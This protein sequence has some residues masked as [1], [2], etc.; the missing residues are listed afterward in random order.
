MS[1]RAY[2]DNVIV[3]FDKDETKQDPDTGL[4]LVPSKPGARGGKIATVLASGPGY[5]TQPTKEAPRGV[6][7]PN[8]VKPGE[9]V[10][11]DALAGQDY[12]LDLTI[13]RHN[14]NLEFEEMVGE[15]GQFRIV[16]E[17]EIL[18]VIEE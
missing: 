10:L 12:S 15:R 5:W 1:V 13:P 14:K 3:V 8:E 7:I 4:W 11:L 2:A 6:F 17:Q 9:R 18:G 16:R